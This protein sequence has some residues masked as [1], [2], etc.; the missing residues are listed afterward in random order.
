MTKVIDIT[1]QLGLDYWTGE[2]TPY[3]RA[4]LSADQLEAVTQS[5]VEPRIT[6]RTLVRQ[7]WAV[8]GRPE[9]CLPPKGWEPSPA[10]VASVK[11]SPMRRK[12]STKPKR[13]T[14]DTLGEISAALGGF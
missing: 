9:W 5:R 13:A 12:P 10:S 1:H 11:C 2:A 3:L 14:A 6:Q 7:I 4:H 8:D